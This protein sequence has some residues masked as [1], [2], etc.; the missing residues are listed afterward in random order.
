MQEQPT[1]SDEEIQLMLELLSSERDELPSEIRHTDNA[2][3]H[4]ELQQRLKRVGALIEK[5][6][7]AA[8]H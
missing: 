3:Y 5:L 1:F 2:R 8:V 4:D 7:H 6:Q